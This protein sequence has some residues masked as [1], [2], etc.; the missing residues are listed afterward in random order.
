MTFSWCCKA[1]GS[2]ISLKRNPTK[3][4]H[5]GHC[6]LHHVARKRCFPFVIDGIGQSRYIVIRF[7]DV[8]MYLT[9]NWQKGTKWQLKNDG[10]APNVT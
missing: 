10:S 8:N 3:P 7:A 2:G 1:P 5:W 9:D 4:T 6:F